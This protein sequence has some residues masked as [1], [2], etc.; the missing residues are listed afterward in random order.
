LPGGA[1][2]WTAEPVTPLDLVA[3]SFELGLSVCG[4]LLLATPAGA[5]TAAG[6]GLRRFAAVGAAVV[7]GITCAALAA[8]P[9]GHHQQGTPPHVHG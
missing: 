2:P 1:E 8:T 4:V 6:P 3:T 5:V 9:N 7:T